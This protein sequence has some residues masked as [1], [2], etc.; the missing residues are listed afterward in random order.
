M[1]RDTSGEGDE[2]KILETMCAR[3]KTNGSCRKSANVMPDR[4]VYIRTD[5]RNPIIPFLTNIKLDN[6]I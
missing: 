2:G 4:Y 3:E 5:T 1:T 6:V